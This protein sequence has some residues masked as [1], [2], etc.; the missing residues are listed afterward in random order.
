MRYRSPSSDCRQPQSLQGPSSVQTAL[1]VFA[2]MRLRSGPFE[3]PAIVKPPALPEDNYID[4]WI[5]S[6][7]F[8][9]IFHPRTFELQCC[10]YT[11]VA[12]QS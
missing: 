8:A 11:M 6:K 1:R 7:G 5:P 9:F 10:P 2:F 12:R 4:R 3:G